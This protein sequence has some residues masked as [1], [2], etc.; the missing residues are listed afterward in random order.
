M[1]PYNKRF[2][3]VH[4]WESKARKNQL[5]ITNNSFMVDEDIFLNIRIYKKSLCFNISANSII[6][7]DSLRFG[8]VWLYVY[9]DK[10]ARLKTSTT[11]VDPFNN[12]FGR[13]FP[14]YPEPDQLFFNKD[15]SRMFIWNG[16]DW[17]ERDAVII[18]KF[19]DTGKCVETKKRTSQGGF[20][21]A[22]FL[23][24]ELIKD[25]FNNFI[26]IFERNGYSFLTVEEYSNLGFKEL[27]NITLTTLMHRSIA[28]ANINKFTVVNRGTDYTVYPASTQSTTSAVAL[29]LND[30]QESEECV[31]LERGFLY[32]RD[33]QWVSPAH[34]PI[35]YNADGGLTFEL[36]EN[37]AI[38][39]QKVGHVVDLNTIYFNPEPKFIL[40]RP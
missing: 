8:S 29:L 3:H 35:F 11:S 19:D 22:P 9:I 20:R 27:K 31:I 37:G 15:I 34:T 10:D 16:K 18:G 5:S 39:L 17:I 36:P 33:R 32:T 21:A 1:I 23:A 24:R 30:A 26:R 25:K 7:I 28:T 14:E 12:L 4:A 6:P 2:K 38:A 40:K 13:E